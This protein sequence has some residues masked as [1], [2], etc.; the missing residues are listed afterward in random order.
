MDNEITQ[1][2]KALH[3]RSM[4]R[5]KNLVRA[6]LFKKVA[7]KLNTIQQL[8]STIDGHDTLVEAIYREC[9]ELKGIL[10]D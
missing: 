10:N 6:R 3:S 5:I 8:A 2:L 7:H 1:Q 9:E 4:V